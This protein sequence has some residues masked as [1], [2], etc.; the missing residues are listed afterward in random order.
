METFRRYLCRLLNSSHTVFALPFALIGFTLAI[1]TGGASFSGMKLCS[2]YCMVFAR[3]MAF[4]RFI[5]QRLM[6][7]IRGTSVRR[8]SGWSY[9][10]AGPPRLWYCFVVLHLLFVL[11]Y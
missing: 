11:V 2:F 8:N 10:A 5:D 4:N 9:I 7:V 6:P 1:H 3:D